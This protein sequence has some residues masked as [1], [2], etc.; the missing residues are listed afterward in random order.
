M[1][2]PIVCM[3]I[4]I[5]IILVSGFSSLKFGV[6]PIYLAELFLSVFPLANALLTI[7]FVAPY[8]RYTLDIIRNAVKVSPVDFSTGAAPER[9]AH[10]NS[11]I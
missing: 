10:D 11:R 1:L 2:S 4:P 8:R 9:S 5:A 7:G 6:F 3:L